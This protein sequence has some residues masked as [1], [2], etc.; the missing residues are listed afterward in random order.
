MLCMMNVRK[1]DKM[2][3]LSI[4]LLL[5]DYAK[6]TS[7]YIFTHCYSQCLYKDNDPSL[8]NSWSVTGKQLCRRKAFI[9]S[10]SWRIRNKVSTWTVGTLNGVH[11][12][13]NK[14]VFLWNKYIHCVHFISYV[15]SVC[16]SFFHDLT[17]FNSCAA[18]C[19]SAVLRKKNP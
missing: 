3:F 1:P 15:C 7:F 18:I 16:G 14:S 10:W 11:T 12:S 4:G 2:T 19:H 5:E 8:A 9:S 17:C 13:P 6:I